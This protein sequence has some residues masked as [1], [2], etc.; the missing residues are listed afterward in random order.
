MLSL[1]QCPVCHPAGPPGPEHVIHRG[2]SEADIAVVEGG[3]H[4]E[5]GVAGQRHAATNCV[6]QSHGPVPLEAHGVF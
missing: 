3:G 1:E 6:F 4:P 2:G 5:A